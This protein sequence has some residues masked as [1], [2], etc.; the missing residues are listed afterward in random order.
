MH[1]LSRWLIVVQVALVGLPTL[2]CTTAAA[3]DQTTQLATRDDRRQEEIL[4]SAVVD[5]YAARGLTVDV[6]SEKHML[7]SSKF[8]ELNPEVRRR[9]ISR[10]IASPRGVALNV[11]AEYQRA[12]RRGPELLWVEADD[13]LTREEAGRDE[14]QLG[15]LILDLFR[16]RT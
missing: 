12:D 15:K 1:R 11:H 14:Q 10:I 4:F 13:P 16:E 7:V 6:A 3:P 2:G 9:F 5:T 8:E